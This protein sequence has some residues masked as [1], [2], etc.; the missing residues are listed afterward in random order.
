MGGET[1]PLQGRQPLEKRK[2]DK[3]FFNIA[4][5]DFN[6][7]KG[8]ISVVLQIRVTSASPRQYR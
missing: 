7:K 3:L 1:P 2:K 4:Y 8:S 5:Q 6:T